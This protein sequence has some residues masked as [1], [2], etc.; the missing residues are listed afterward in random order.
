MMSSL[1][2]IMSMNTVFISFTNNAFIVFHVAAFVFHLIP[3]IDIKLE[4]NFSNYVENCN[5]Y[6]IR[7]IKAKRLR[8]GITFC[9]DTIRF[10]YLHRHSS[11]LSFNIGSIL[12][13]CPVN[14]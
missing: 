4:F 10:D 11:P 13:L 12:G 7:V 14:S 3:R 5:I 6:F 1:F 9:R 2:Y 8:I